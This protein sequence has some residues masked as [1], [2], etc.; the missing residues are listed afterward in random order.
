M[1]PRAAY[2]RRGSFPPDLVPAVVV[3]AAVGRGGA[4]EIPVGQPDAGGGA[5]DADARPVHF[6]PRPRRGPDPSHA[7]GPPGV[8]EVLP[9]GVAKRLRPVA[10]AEAIDL[11]D[12]QP[13]VGQF[14]RG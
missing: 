1:K 7:V 14:L 11:D 9:A 5:V 10:R 8:A 6:G 2:A 13:G 4:V 12:D 3:A